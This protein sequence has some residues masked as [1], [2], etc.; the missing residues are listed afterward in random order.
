MTNLINIPNKLL[1]RSGGIDSRWSGLIFVDYSP[2]IKINFAIVDKQKAMS[3]CINRIWYKDVL[4]ILIISF[5][6]LYLNLIK[7]LSWS[8]SGIKVAYQV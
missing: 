2:Q 4:N 1:L 8:M 6:K 5:L 7:N 3:F